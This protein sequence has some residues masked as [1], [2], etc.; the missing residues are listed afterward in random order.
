MTSRRLINKLLQ[1]QSLSSLQSM[2]SMQSVDSSVANDKELQDMIRANKARLQQ[3]QQQSG[4]PSSSAA[5]SMSSTPSTAEQLGGS[6]V[7]PAAGQST[8]LFDDP[9]AADFDPLVLDML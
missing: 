4:L 7:Q 5:E 6:A 3:Q 2:H 9:A 1:I 8:S